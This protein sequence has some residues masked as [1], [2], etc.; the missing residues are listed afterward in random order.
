[1]KRSILLISLSFIISSQLYAQWQLTGNSGT[2]PATH[3]VG[4]T[5]NVP[6]KFR[7]NNIPLGSLSEDNIFFGNSAGIS[8]TTGYWLTGFGYNTLRANT[9]GSRNV[10]IGSN[11]LASNT[12]GNENT[13]IGYVA[14]G[15]NTTGIE[16]TGLGYQALSESTTGSSNTAVGAFSNQSNA[17]GYANSSLGTWALYRARNRT[18]NVA[19]GES[20]LY[21]T[22]TN[23]P[24]H[25]YDGSFN[26]AV[27][28][29]SMY[30]NTTGY[31]NTAIG[32]QALYSI[33][34]GSYNT[35][36]GYN[37]YP[38]NGTISN[39]T[40]IGYNVGHY[41]SVS[42]SVEIGNFSVG[43][44]GGQVG[45][46]TY[47]D[48]RIKE[49]IKEDVKGLEFIMKLKPVTYNLN[50]HKQHDMVNQGKKINDEKEWPDKYKIESKRITGFIAQEVEEA[51]KQINYDFDGVTKPENPNGLYSLR[52]SEFVV[53][54]VKAMQEQQQ[55]I[56]KME[57]RIKELEK[58]IAACATN[59]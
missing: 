23:D 1:M 46:S 27:G 19:I 17:G 55:M 16:N 24:V 48:K 32:F 33:T 43:W 11:C 18:R 6:L 30:S 42:N 2:N 14:I 53:P 47:S 54:L 12:T 39:Y 15:N 26:T 51:A 38:V 57:Q 4:T 8:N 49:N 5:N 28:S 29:R 40:G 50:I 58:K 56:D 7:V 25:S 52:Y 34:T 10:A 59:L 35:A 31:L 22:G 13:G 37:A 21:S 41:G 9:T 20:A 44:I 36:I 3:F 45:W